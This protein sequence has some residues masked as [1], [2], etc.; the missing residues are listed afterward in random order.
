VAVILRAADRVAVPWKNGGG[1]TREV[2]V[3][4]PGS[5]L[6]NFAW[7]VSLAEVRTGGPFSTFTGIDRQMAV[8]SGRLELSI[9]DREPLTLCA[10][11]DPVAFAGELPVSS[12]PLQSPVLD[13]NVMTRRAAFAARLRRCHA[14]GS[15]T[16]AVEAESTLLLALVPLILHVPC[17]EESLAALDAV[18]LYLD[19]HRRGEVSIEGPALDFWLIEISA[20]AA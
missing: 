18:H 11:S 5:T 9:A 17:M 2:A 19:R 14:R 10:D 12:E 8:L 7:R 15:A 13:L 1:L 4:P 6:A 16:V 3:H 20:A